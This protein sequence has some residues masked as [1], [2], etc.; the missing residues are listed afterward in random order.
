MDSQ[1]MNIYL[2]E[3]G[4]NKIAKPL[5]TP[6]LISIPQLRQFPAPYP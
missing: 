4:L 6:S 2:F 1:D 3:D 5:K